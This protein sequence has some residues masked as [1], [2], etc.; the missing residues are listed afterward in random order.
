MYKIFCF[1]INERTG[2]TKFNIN[3]KEK[4]QNKKSER[5]NDTNLITKNNHKREEK[6]I[7]R[8]M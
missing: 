8:E 7:V 3:Q 2:A 5:E 6:N 4:E 1:L